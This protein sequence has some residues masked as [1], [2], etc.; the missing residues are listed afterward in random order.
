MQGEEVRPN[1][2]GPTLLSAHCTGFHEIYPKLQLELAW[3]KAEEGRGFTR[4]QLWK[5][6]KFS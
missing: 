3:K 5:N 6:E 4:T 2:L 1:I